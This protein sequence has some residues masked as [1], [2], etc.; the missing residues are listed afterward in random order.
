MVTLFV[1]GWCL[2]SV[3]LCYLLHRLSWQS[4]YYADP[5]RRLC[6]TLD[7]MENKLIDK[8]IVLDEMLTSAD[9]RPTPRSKHDL[10]IYAGVKQ[11]WWTS[12][13]Q[14]NVEA[15]GRFKRRKAAQGL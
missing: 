6:G 13:P 10:A 9:S 8:T 5:T 15:V 7:K 2:G 4:S 1:V 3:A 12:V 11:W 14:S